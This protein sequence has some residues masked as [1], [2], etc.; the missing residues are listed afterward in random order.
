MAISSID[1]EH[2]TG[3]AECCTFNFRASILSDVNPGL[4]SMLMYHF[5]KVFS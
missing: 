4:A 1:N 3:F 5:P 2:I